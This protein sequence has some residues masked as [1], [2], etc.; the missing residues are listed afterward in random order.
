MLT[1]TD[2]LTFEI[3]TNDGFED[4]YKNKNSFD[5]KECLENSFLDA[6]NK[7]VLVWWKTKL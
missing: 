3:K 2:I 7:K 1:D 4:F 5:F 6:T